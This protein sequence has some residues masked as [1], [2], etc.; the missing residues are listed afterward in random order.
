MCPTRVQVTEIKYEQRHST[1]CSLVNQSK[2]AECGAV[3]VERKKMTLNEIF[4]YVDN[5]KTANQ[6][7]SHNCNMACKSKEARSTRR[8]NNQKVQSVK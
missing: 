3:M 5:T 4:N 1:L 2:Q 7:E 8:S 6:A